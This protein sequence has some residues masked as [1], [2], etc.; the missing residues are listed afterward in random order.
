MADQEL[1]EILS[2]YQNLA[3]SEHQS[4]VSGLL[5]SATFA[6][7]VFSA[8]QIYE[9]RGPVLCSVAVR[10]VYPGSDF[11]PSRIRTVTVPDPGSASKF[12]LFNPKKWF[13]SS[14]KYDPG[15]SSRIRMLN[16]YPSR[17][18]GS[19]RHRIPD[20]DPQHWCCGTRNDLLRFRFRLW[21]NFVSGSVSGF[22]VQTNIYQ[23]FNNP[24][25]V[26]KQNL[27]FSMLEA[28]SFAE[29]VGLIFFFFWLFCVPFFVGS[30][31]KSG[32]GMHSGSAKA[33]KIAFPVP[34]HWCTLVLRKC[35]STVLI[36]QAVS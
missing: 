31:F 32:S 1:A 23:F 36:I 22:G 9:V 3:E 29:K 21:K 12:Q 17:I 5:H 16:F 6:A 20:P 11:F 18:Q 15:C 26:Y 34:Q 13:L 27:A 28:A 33:K 24:K 14:R 10:D 8:L 30:G 7:T 4:F 35:W 2:E 19:K 25:N